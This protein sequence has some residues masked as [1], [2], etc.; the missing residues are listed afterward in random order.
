MQ[1]VFFFFFT[2]DFGLCVLK[3]S[4]QKWVNLKE[5]CATIIEEKNPLVLPNN[6]LYPYSSI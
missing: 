3:K 1:D 6:I 2:I 5:T 4:I